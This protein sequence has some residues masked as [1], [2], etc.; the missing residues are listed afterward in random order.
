MNTEH[1]KYDLE[2]FEDGGIVWG[3][4]ID[5]SNYGKPLSWLKDNEEVYCHWSG[6]WSDHTSGGPYHVDYVHGWGE[7]FQIRLPA[8][9]WAYP[10]IAKGFTPWAG[11]DVAPDDW[12]P[13]SPV[14][15]CN[16][17]QPKQ[18]EWAWGPGDGDNIII[19][20]RRK[21]EAVPTDTDTVTIKL[22]TER[23]WRDLI[24]S[25]SGLAD[26]SR[27]AN[28]TIRALRTLG[29]IHEETRAE[30]FARETGYVVTEAVDA[31]LEWERGA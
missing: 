19:G 31:A 2:A 1:S 14:L 10:V 12:E 9:H 13:G 4:K 18:G 7:G 6:H 26:F 22:M 29:I 15:F 30:R 11:G 28:S 8:D 17:D 21:A 25:E 3:A 16:G 27:A 20:Y 23:Q 5:A 24:I